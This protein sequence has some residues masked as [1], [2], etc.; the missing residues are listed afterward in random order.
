MSAPEIIDATVYENR[1]VAEETRILTLSVPH[2]TDPPVAGQF[3]NIRVGHGTE[4]MLRRPLGVF[5]YEDKGAADRL[6]FIMEIAGKGTA[7]LAAISPGERIS[8][9]GPL[10]NGFRLPA[11]VSTLLCVSG[12]VGIAPLAYL[13]STLAGGGVRCDLLAGFRSEN[14]IIDCLGC[15]RDSVDLFTDDGSFGIRGNPCDLLEER[16]AEGYD[17]VV[18]TGPRAMMA[19]VSRIAEAN[20]TR[21]LL[22]LDERMA[23]GIGLCRGCVTRGRHG[24]NLCI[25]S[26]GPVFDS[27]LVDWKGM[28]R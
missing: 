8:L 6:G 28:G 26:D 27:R 15:F 17:A 3:Y 14:R 20:G 11:S 12:G 22:S 7:L 4:H 5:S 10:G 24:E 18:S 2:L 1:G 23:C 19:S 13:A 25:C 16:L 21:C 9:F